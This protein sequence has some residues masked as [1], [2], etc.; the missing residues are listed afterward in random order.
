MKEHLTIFSDFDQLPL[1]VIIT[2][3]SHPIGIVQ[4]SHGMCE[5]KERYLDFMKFLNQHG[6]VCCIH[7]H[8]GHGKSILKEDDL[9]YFY[10][11]G[12]IGIVEDVHQLTL[13]MK[14]R[15]P[16]LPIY[17]F[18]HSMGSLV[19]RCYIKKY[20]QDIDGLFVCGSPSHNQAVD[21]GIHLTTLLSKIKGDHYRSHLIQ[22]IGFDAFNK[23]FNTQI[24]NSWI[25][26]DENIVNAYNQNPLC[27]FIFTNN[28]FYSLF[29]L[30][31]ETYS[32]E[33]WLLHQP[34]LPIHFIAGSDD[35][36]ITNEKEFL[37]AVQFVRDIGYQNVS[38]HLFKEMRHEILNEKNNKIVYKHILKTLKFWAS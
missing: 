10:E 27:R 38:S 25:C 21:I 19:V 14:K 12:H 7:D 1:D 37:K 13:F 5:H 33:H 22:K 3:P 18:G 16:N 20:D 24:P 30:M 36:C 31:K 2:S 28:G 8:R 35:P 17:L 4:L 15:Y 23:K 9:G 11:N 29:Q 34:T 26:S 6:Y 32:K